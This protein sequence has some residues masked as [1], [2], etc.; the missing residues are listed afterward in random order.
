M[1]TKRL[2]E[3]LRDILKAEQAAGPPAKPAAPTSIFKVV[4]EESRMVYGFASVSVAPTAKVE[5]QDGQVVDSHKDLITTKALRSLAHGL[6]KGQRAGKIDHKGLKR[7]DIVEQMV[8]DTDLWK[9]LGGYFQDMG[10]LTPAQAQVFKDIQ[11][12]GLLMGFHVA[13]DETWALAKDSEF[14]LSIGASR[15]FVQDIPD[16]G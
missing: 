6:I 15:A 11:F 1:K 14:E 13:D 12:E 3:Q 7:S 4:N 10:V 2:L 16:A 5:T 8:F 9:A